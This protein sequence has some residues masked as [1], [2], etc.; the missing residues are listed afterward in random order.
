MISHW[1]VDV[2]QSDILAV[3]DT[4]VAFAFAN[5]TYS[6]AR[7]QSPTETLRP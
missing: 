5:T 7:R 2:D 6:V 1:T 4:S 3:V